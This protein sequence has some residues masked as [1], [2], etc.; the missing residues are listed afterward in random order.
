M[1]KTNKNL[2]ERVTKIASIRTDEV[3]TSINVSKV[4]ERY[5]YADK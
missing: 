4:I 2:E 5:F 1:K 3:S